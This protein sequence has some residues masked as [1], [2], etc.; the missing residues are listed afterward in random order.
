MELKDISDLA[1]DSG[2]RVFTEIV[3]KGGQVKGINA[4]HL[5]DYSRKQIDELT[6]YVKQYGAG[7]LAYLALT[8]E[9]EERSSFAKFLSDDVKADLIKRLDGSPGDLLLFVAD[10]PEVV[11]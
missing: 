10:A 1:P 3:E 11:I 7:G 6:E 5:G 2:F 8:S 9:G 4:K